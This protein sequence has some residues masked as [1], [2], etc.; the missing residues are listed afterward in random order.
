MRK[1]LLMIVAILATTQFASAEDDKVRFGSIRIP[2]P[3]LIGIEKGYF[4][5]RNIDLEMTF[6][7]SGA[8]I[9]PAVATGQVDA[10]LT[11]SGAPLFNA[12]ARGIE[13]KI[14]ADALTLDPKAPQSDPVSIVVRQEL[15]D[16]GVVKSAKDL[17]GRKIAI[18]APGQILDII[19]R[20]F[21][22]NADIATDNYKLVSMP[23]P[24][25]IVALKSGA[26]D[27][28]VLLDPFTTFAKDRGVGDRLVRGS[29]IV[30]GVQQAFIVYGTRMTEKNRD[31][32][33]RFMEAY[34]E[35]NQWMR[36]TL[37]TPGGRKQVAAIY[38]KFLPAKSAELYERIT[39][40]TAVK[41]LAVN[42]AGNFGLK[43]QVGKL[44]DRG[45]LLEVPAIDDHVDNGF[46][47]NL[48]NTT[49]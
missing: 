11:T 48:S 43:W 14:V 41:G 12:L 10:A 31:L 17:A 4:K 44:N 8:E 27:A 47:Q 19:A 30:P 29:D 13:L 28:A 46:V 22:Q 36:K 39:L 40:V 45:L 21:M 3:I 34:A 35:A 5:A 32:G 25:M 23:L 16:S 6:F 9:A 2:T 37:A 20:Q 42:V 26:V 18:T 24:D 33:Q 7:K 38:Q 1:L 49:K 15:L